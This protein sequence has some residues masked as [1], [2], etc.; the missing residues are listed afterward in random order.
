MTSPWRHRERRRV[1][2]TEAGAGL[3]CKVVVLVGKSSW[4]S[5]ISVSVI[6]GGGRASKQKRAFVTR[7]VLVCRRAFGRAASVEG[8][9]IIM[10]ST[11]AR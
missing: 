8:I 9:I 11:A 3:R 1:L 10:Y 5:K 7:E 6:R 2:Q 4:L